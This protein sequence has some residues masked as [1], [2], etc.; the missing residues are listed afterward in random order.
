MGSVK[1]VNDSLGR[2][3]KDLNETIKSISHNE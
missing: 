1:G 2:L 3:R